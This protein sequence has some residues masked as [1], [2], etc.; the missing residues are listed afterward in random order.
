MA[1][2]YTSTKTK[3]E[4]DTGKRY[5]ETTIYPKLSP[6]NSDIYIITDEG[7]RLDML[8]Y[9]YYGDTKMWWVIASANNINDAT[10]YIESGI[11]LRIPTNIQKLFNDL[12]KVNK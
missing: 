2:R 11:Q 7:D 5:M 1:S 10:Y 8:A 4:T 3:T 9:K 12:T 6:T